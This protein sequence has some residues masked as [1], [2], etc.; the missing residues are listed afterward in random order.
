[1]E[2]TIDRDITRIRKVFRTAGSQKNSA[3]PSVGIVILDFNGLEDTLRCLNALREVEYPNL[4]VHVIDNASDSDNASVIARAFP[5]VC[6]SRNATN[7]GFGHGSNQGMRRALEDDAAYVLFLNNDT[8]LHPDTI[9][10]L[11]DV[12]ERDPRVGIAGPRVCYLDPPHRIQNLG[13]TYNRWLGAPRAV[14]A[15]K[16]AD[17]RPVRA[18]ELAWIMG[19]A[20]FARREVLERT[21]GFD[22]DFFLYWED[23]Y[24]CYQ[25]RQLGYSLQVVD[26]AEVL[27]RKTVGSEFSKRHVY[28]M[29][30]GQ[31]TFVAKTASP[32]QK[33]TLVIGMALIAIAYSIL[34]LV[35]QG[36]F[37]TPVIYQ[38][39]VD[40]YTGHP[41]RHVRFPSL[42]ALLRSALTAASRRR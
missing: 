41:K 25:A 10:L 9:D 2:T 7:T 34:G 39:V 12:M 37:V 15:G 35:K 13:Y 20:M 6:V 1:M 17:W 28:H 36:S 5:D 16:T 42:R 22:K 29:F 8:V 3:R 30:L 24:L 33:P 11:V 4:L 19:C 27:H 14:G 26:S 23:H 21:G 38:A 18:P 32:W 40:F 31:I